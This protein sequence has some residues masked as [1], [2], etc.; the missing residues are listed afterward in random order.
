MGLENVPRYIEINYY[1]T[2]V[3]AFDFLIQK[4]YFYIMHIYLTQV[5]FLYLLK[6]DLSWI[7]NISWNNQNTYCVT[8]NL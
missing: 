4:Y 6:G 3:H 7:F 5:L 1:R 8:G 2:E